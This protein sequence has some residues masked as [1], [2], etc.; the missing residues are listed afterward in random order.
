MVR[1]VSRAGTG[2]GS[3]RPQGL[4]ASKPRHLHGS[5]LRHNAKD[6]ITMNEFRPSTVVIDRQHPDILMRA[7]FLA[8]LGRP[9]TR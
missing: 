9:F 5:E 3:H 6:V 4:Q 2:T 1:R 7:R 8:L